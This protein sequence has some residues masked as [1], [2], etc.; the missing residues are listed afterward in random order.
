MTEANNKQTL[1]SL[2]AEQAQTITSITIPLNAISMF[3]SLTVIVIY[4]L[5]RRYYPALADRV[6]FRLGVCTSISDLVYSLFQL[7]SILETKPGFWCGFTVWGFVFAS[8]LS[9]FF[10]DCIA[11][12]LHIMFLREYRGRI[13][14]ERYYVP[15]SILLALI[16]SSLPLIQNMYGWNAPEEFCWYRDSGERYNIIWQWTTLFTWLELSVLYCSVVIIS[17]IVKLKTKKNL[18]DTGNLVSSSS[19]DNANPKFSC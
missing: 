2:T 8:L 17:V 11:L 13:D 1:T 15:A 10:S 19:S 14:F 3:A 6:S 4:A 5:M 18:F 9:T 7:L 12:N 16:I